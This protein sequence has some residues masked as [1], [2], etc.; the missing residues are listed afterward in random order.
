MPM[1]QMLVG[2]GGEEEKGTSGNPYTS[3]T[4]LRSEGLTNDSSKYLSLGGYT[5]RIAIDDSGYAKFT[6]PGNYYT[7]YYYGNGINTCCGSAQA[8][9]TSS[10]INNHT[11]GNRREWATESYTGYNDWEWQDADGTTINNGFF[12]VMAGQLNTGYRSN[13]WWLGHNDLETGNVFEIKYS[14]GTISGPHT[15]SD[16]SAG[17]DYNIMSHD[18][19]SQLNSWVGNSK[20]WTSMKTNGGGD[21][22]AMIITW[23]HSG[24]AIK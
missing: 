24:M 17:P 6:I 8:A 4:E 19:T 18:Y 2:M 3:W 23:R 20:I 22:A 15:I 14:D 12:N 9:C 21:P 16:N 5:Y 13:Q 11:V 1:Q 7:R 10:S